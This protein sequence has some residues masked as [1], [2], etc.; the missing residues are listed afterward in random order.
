[1]PLY[2]FRPLYGVVA[3]LGERL[4]RIEEVVSSILIHSISRG[5]TLV[6]PRVGFCRQMRGNS[7]NA[8]ATLAA[9]RGLLRP[10]NAIVCVRR[11]T[12]REAPRTRFPLFLN[13]CKTPRHYLLAPTRV[14]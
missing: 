12:R 10:S 5:L 7:Y 2:T 14:M 9:S 1:M 11:V 3:Q 13:A 6:R 4:G 8:H